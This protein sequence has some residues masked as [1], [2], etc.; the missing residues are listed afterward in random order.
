MIMLGNIFPQKLVIPLFPPL[1]KGEFYSS[2]KKRE[3]G[4]DF[5]KLIFNGNKRGDLQ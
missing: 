1:V 2:L 4:R 5:I 3:V